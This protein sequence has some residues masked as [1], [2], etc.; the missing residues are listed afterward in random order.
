MPLLG[1]RIPVMTQ[2]GPETGE[3][4]DGFAPIT[5]PAPRVNDNRAQPGGEPSNAPGNLAFNGAT[6]VAWT[7]DAG[8]GPRAERV[9]RCTYT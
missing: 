6:N 2:Q 3:L 9:R 1:K 5:L 8:A 4:A 7:A